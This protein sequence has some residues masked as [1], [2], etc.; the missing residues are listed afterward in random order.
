MG[1]NFVMLLVALAKHQ[2]CQRSAGSQADHCAA[3][4][5]QPLLGLVQISTW[6]KCNQYTFQGVSDLD[7]KILSGTGPKGRMRIA[8]KGC[9]LMRDKRLAA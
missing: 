6:E 4:Q 9:F 7:C 2:A 1:Q 5:M 3:H 8:P